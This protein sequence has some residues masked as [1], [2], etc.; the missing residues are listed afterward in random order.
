[1]LRYSRYLFQKDHFSRAQNRVKPD[2]FVV[3]PEVK[4]SVSETQTL[5]ESE[6][7]QIGEAI[8]TKRGR[9]LKGRGD[10]G[11]PGLEAAGLTIEID[12]PP[13]YHRNIIGWASNEKPQQLMQATDLANQTVLVLLEDQRLRGGHLHKGNWQA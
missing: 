12:E 7:W 11:E 1:M 2:A 4:A 10:F 8:A 3:A 9:S 5:K 13:D 6:V